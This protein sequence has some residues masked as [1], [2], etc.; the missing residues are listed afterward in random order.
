MYKHRRSRRQVELVVTQEEA[1]PPA[2]IPC[3]ATL[4]RTSQRRPVLEVPCRR[5]PTGTAGIHVTLPGD[6]YVYFAD[7]VVPTTTSGKEDFCTLVLEL[8]LA[9]AGPEQPVAH[10]VASVCLVR[11]EGMDG[12]AVAQQHGNTQPTYVGTTRATPTAIQH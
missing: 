4:R 8:L 11:V 9:G 10:P 6:L 5:C 12:C 2:G 3:R 1:R 7:V